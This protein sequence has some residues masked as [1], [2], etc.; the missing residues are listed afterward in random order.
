MAA[1]D[2]AFAA[3][4]AGDGPPGP[5]SPGDH[6]RPAVA[7]QDGCA[8]AR[9]AGAVRAV[10]DGG[11][12]LLPLDQE[13]PLAADPGRA[14][15]PG[16]GGRQARLER[17]HGRR[18]QH[19]RPSSR[20]RRQRGQQ[21]QA[22]G[23]SRGGFGSKLHLRCERA[24]RPIAFVL[25]AG[26]RHEQTA[27]LPLMAAGAVRRQGR[28]RPRSRPRALLGDRGSTGRRVRNHL[29][30]RGIT[31]IIPQ[32]KTETKPR[33]MDWQT[34]R[35]RNVVERLVGRLKEYRRLATRGARPRAG[36]AGPGGQARQL[37]PR[38]RPSRRYSHV[39]LKTDPSRHPAP[40]YRIRSV[41]SRLAVVAQGRYYQ[42]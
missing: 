25:T 28:G 6:Q 14:A 33:L 12:T 21:N 27:F 18:H 10:A 9:P 37:L 11:D 42:Q 19:P 35:E 29:R 34:Y 2:A 1:F 20:R 24:G 22:L 23:R 15:G 17:A 36:Q 7:D 31:A 26:E 5:R 13:R 40:L 41:N 39:A 32:L 38:L 8:L 3:A 4:T 30:R 16:R